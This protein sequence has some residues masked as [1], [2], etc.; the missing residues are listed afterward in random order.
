MARSLHPYAKASL[1][2][3]GVAAASNGAIGLLWHLRAWLFPPLAYLNI[4]VTLGLS[5]APVCLLPSSIWLSLRPGAT[6]AA[7]VRRPRRGDLLALALGF[8]VALGCVA[9]MA[10]LAGAA[11]YP[12]RHLLD[13]RWA[14][15][16][17]PFP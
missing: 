6:A 7:R 11:E 17:P 5:L 9:A 4:Y 16:T 3:A 1:W 15:N 12:L 10:S 8:L 13:E 2:C 14:P